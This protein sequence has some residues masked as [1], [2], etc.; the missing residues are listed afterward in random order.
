[1]KVPDRIWVNLQREIYF[2]MSSIKRAG[3]TEYRVVKKAKRKGKKGGGDG[4]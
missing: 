3:W 4:G 1:M 2:E